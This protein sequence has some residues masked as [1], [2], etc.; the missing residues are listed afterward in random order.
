MTDVETD[1][2]ISNRYSSKAQLDKKAIIAVL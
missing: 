1:L 2:G